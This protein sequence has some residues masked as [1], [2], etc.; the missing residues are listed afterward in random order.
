MCDC[1]EKVK[2]AM[3]KKMEQ[4]SGFTE[5][6]SEP[7][8]VNISIYPEE[9]PYFPITGRYMTGKKSRVFKIS[10]Y[11]TYCPFCGLKR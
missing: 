4:E 3:L 1:T 7:G 11:P 10:L 5:V 9:V 6:V 8:F 2:E